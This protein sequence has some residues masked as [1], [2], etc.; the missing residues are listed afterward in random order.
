[1]RKVGEVNHENLLVKK[2]YPGQIKGLGRVGNTKMTKNGKVWLWGGQQ[3]KKGEVFGRWTMKPS[4]SKKT[5]RGRL[6]MG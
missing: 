2:S 3:E 5:K 6:R 1:L 4:Q